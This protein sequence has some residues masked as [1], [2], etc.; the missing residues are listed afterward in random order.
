MKDDLRET[1]LELAA[2][3]R[4]LYDRGYSF[5]TAGNVSALAGEVMLVSPT[6]SSLAELGEGSFS[7]MSLEGKHLEGPRPSKEAHL[8]LAIY[9]A[10]PEAK[11]VIHLHSPYATALACLPLRE[12]ADHLP[13]YTP[14]FAMRIPGL[15]VI[16]YFPPGHPDL[17][18][19]VKEAAMR[20]PVLL[21]KNHGSL[22]AG[23]TIREASSLAEE[24][25]QQARLYFLLRG[26]GEP[27]TA[28]QIALLRT[29]K[30]S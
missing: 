30:G 28:D 5:G 24:L 9:A 27:L 3:A 4:S 23:R 7:G 2:C 11:A 8:H 26:L 18:E 1:A 29:R 12:S 20:S 16:P 6:N 15:P 25:E 21:L 13:I 14:Y 17:A 10:R 19:H 22:A